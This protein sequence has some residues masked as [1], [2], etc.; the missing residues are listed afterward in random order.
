ME[1]TSVRTR[2]PEQTEERITQAALELFGIY[3]YERTSV[4]MI[5][6][7]A[8]YSKGAFYN[9][10]PSKED[11]LFFLL[12]QRVKSN[13]ERIDALY[14]QMSHPGQW[15]RSVLENLL[16]M[17]DRD[18]QW[19]ALSVEFMVQAM[20]DERLGKRM[21]LIHQDWRRLISN[22]LRTT[23]SHRAGR[24]AADPETIAAAVMAMVDG[25]IIH[26]SMEPELLTS[27]RINQLV[28]HL[29]GMDEEE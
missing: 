15:L 23:D 1:T 26:A 22:K 7:E 3:G 19:A 28:E 29:V 18:K 12:E 21:A 10:F 24:M 8:G 17:G 20:R 9:H 6:R 27:T 14:G 25:F 11:L 16:H 13:Q 4:D 5:V 2:N